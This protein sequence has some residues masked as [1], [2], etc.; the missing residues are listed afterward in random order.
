M[1]SAGFPLRKKD[2]ARTDWEPQS[3]KK[4][5]SDQLDLL[6]SRSGEIVADDIFPRAD[7]FAVGP[8]AKSKSLSI[9]LK[10]DEL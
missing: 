6:L 7:F 5:N 9:Q 10:G 2:E 4:A 1:C 8:G 3:G